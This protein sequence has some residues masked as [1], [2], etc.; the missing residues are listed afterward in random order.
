MFV[1][2]LGLVG[3]AA[4]TAEQ[5]RKEVGVRKVLGASTRQLVLLL[6][7]EVVALVLVAFAVAAPLAWVA[8][9]RWLEGFAYRV[10]LGPAPFLAAGA[11]ALAVA[12]ATVGGQALRAAQADPV[13]ALRTE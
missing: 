4:F 5:R 7:R 6:T 8:M 3:L 11:L 13:K 12:L 1:A 2:C 9:G 10:E